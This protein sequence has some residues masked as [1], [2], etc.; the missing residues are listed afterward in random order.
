MRQINRG[1]SHKKLIAWIYGKDPGKLS[2]MPNSQIP[3]LKYHLQ[4]KTKE[5]VR[6]VVVGFQGREGN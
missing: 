4:L 5:D 6:V 2:N 1:K 3:H